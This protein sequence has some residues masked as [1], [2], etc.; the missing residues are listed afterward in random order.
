MEGP[1]EKSEALE[2]SQDLILNVEGVQLSQPSI[3]ALVAS[4]FKL[5]CSKIDNEKLFQACKTGLSL[6]LSAPHLQT[7][8][9]EIT[10]KLSEVVKEIII[11]DKMTEYSLQQIIANIDAYLDLATHKNTSEPLSSS[12]KTKKI[13][14]IIAEFLRRDCNNDTWSDEAIKMMK[15]CCHVGYEGNEFLDYEYLE[16][17]K[18]LNFMCCPRPWE[19]SFTFDLS[20]IMTYLK[21]NLYTGRVLNLILARKLKRWQTQSSKNMDS[22]KTIEDSNLHESNDMITT[23]ISKENEAKLQD[24]L[25]ETESIT[26]KNIHKLL[27]DIC[28]FFMAVGFFDC[29]NKYH[30]SVSFC[31]N[32]SIRVMFFLIL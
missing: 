2:L 25:D 11:N 8:D 30:A 14:E 32:I 24:D 4:L 18:Y 6:M 22:C 16:Q 13:V 5:S 31:I 19:K 26:E 27:K 7:S 15:K 29:F 21:W 20:V 28:D 12:Q 23:K 10:E 3:L 17:E 1:N 9:L